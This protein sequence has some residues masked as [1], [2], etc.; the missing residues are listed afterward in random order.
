MSEHT[1]EPLAALSS[2]GKSPRYLIE[3]FEPRVRDH[4]VSAQVH[5]MNGAAERLDWQM[6]DSVADL[7][8][9]PIRYI[10]TYT[11]AHHLPDIFRH[12]QVYVVS[13]RMRDVIE[14]WLKDFEFLPVEIQL[15]AGRRD[16]DWGK[17]PVLNDYWWL[18]SWRRLDIVDWLKSDMI[19]CLPPDEDS[20]NFG[21]PARAISWKKLVLKNG[22]LEG[23]HFF[24]LAFVA[25]ERRYVSDELRRHLQGEGLRVFF[26]PRTTGLLPW[27][28]PID[29][30]K[31]L[32]RN[33]GGE[34]K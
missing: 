19:P 18:N 24:G 9:T 33:A 10:S 8:D 2:E 20:P 27:R 32:N 4:S 21:S 31:E 26:R 13:R 17:G 1:N 30:E 12:N 15:S 14:P 25:G 29:I 34:E 28:S 16:K 3:M 11:P 6:R 23:E 22:A 5:G 7:V